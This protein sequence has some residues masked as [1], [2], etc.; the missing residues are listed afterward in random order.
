MLAWIVEGARDYL[1]AGLDPPEAVTAATD[2]YREEE[3][4]LGAFIADRCLVGKDYSAPAGELFSAWQTWANEQGEDPGKQT[5]FGRA[6]TE[7]GYLGERGKGQ[8]ARL[9]LAL[10]GPLDDEAGP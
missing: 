3:N 2:A 5:R 6:L 8:R 10:R 1:R 9:G 4:V 7:A